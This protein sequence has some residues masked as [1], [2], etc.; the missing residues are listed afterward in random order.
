MLTSMPLRIEGVADRRVHWHAGRLNGARMLA[1]D[2]VVPR[3]PRLK[4]D[5][6]RVREAGLALSV[7]L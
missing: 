6:R 2:S 7:L 5:A 3:V 4:I 1:S